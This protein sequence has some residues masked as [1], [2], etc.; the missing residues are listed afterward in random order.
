MQV[1]L[2]NVIF[3]FPAVF[4]PS[5][6]GDNRPAYGGKFAIEPGSANAKAIS[7]AIASEAKAKWADKADNVLKILK[8]D[9][10]TAYFEAPYTNKDGDV[11]E[12]F[13][14]MYTLSSRSENVR[15]SAYGKDGTTPLHEADGLIYSGVIVN[16]IVD[17]YA[18]DNAKFGRRINCTLTGVQYSAPGQSFGGSAPAAPGSFEAISDDEA[19]FV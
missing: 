19:D 2:K 15:P 4:T 16:A 5:A 10:R 9:K 6:Y 1:R 17:V 7:A 3:S 8:Q 11:Y 18:Y 13:D 14:G 12:G